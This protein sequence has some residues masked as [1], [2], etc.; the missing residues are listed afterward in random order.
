MAPGCPCATTH[1]R[2]RTR[3]QV[4]WAALNGKV[5]NTYIAGA[6]A[7]WAEESSDEFKRGIWGTGSRDL[8]TQGPP[9]KKP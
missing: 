4:D 7:F 6:K 1:A 9:T 5:A 2:A 3:T 8:V